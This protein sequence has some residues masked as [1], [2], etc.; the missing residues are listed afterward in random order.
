MNSSRTRTLVM[1]MRKDIEEITPYDIFPDKKDGKSLRKTIGQLQLF[2][3]MG[4]I[5][6][7]DIFHS[8]RPYKEYMID[9]IRDL[10]E[11]ENGVRNHFL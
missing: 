11:G 3:T 5:S 10:K 9:W 7:K 2:D 8:F 1:G 4:E 6:E